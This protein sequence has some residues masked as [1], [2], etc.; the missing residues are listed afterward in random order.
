LPV[1]YWLRSTIGSA[2]DPGGNSPH[3]F[4]VAVRRSALPGSYSLRRQSLRRRFA[5]D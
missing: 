2:A 1:S 3:V 4:F 5:A